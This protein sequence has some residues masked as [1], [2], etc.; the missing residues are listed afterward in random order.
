[1]FTLLYLCFIISYQGEIVMN[2]PLS[3]GSVTR[4]LSSSGRLIQLAEPE[5][6]LSSC[7]WIAKTLMVT[8]RMYKLYFTH[9]CRVSPSQNLSYQHIG[10]VF[11]FNATLHSKSFNFENKPLP[12]SIHFHQHE[13][14][15][16]KA[17]PSLLMAGPWSNND[18]WLLCIVC[19]LSVVNSPHAKPSFILFKR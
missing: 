14:K 11:Y 7:F 9:S 8:V 2:N 5:G 17:P 4:Q 15:A 3:C 16:Y 10:I 19:L 12:S 13:S 1:M 18:D 6:K